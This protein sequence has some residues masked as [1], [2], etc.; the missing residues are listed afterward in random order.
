M[1][2]IYL[3]DI[4][5]GFQNALHTVGTVPERKYAKTKPILIAEEIRF[6]I[7]VHPFN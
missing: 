5:V 7:P 2:A 1:Y 3:E 6:D 4:H